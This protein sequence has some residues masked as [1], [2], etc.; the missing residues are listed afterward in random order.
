MR[1]L[2]FAGMLVASIL[3][4][5]NSLAVE[6]F[7]TEQDARKQCPSDTVVWLNT[8]S[9][10]VHYKGGRWY[11]HTKTGAYVCKQEIV[12]QAKHAESATKAVAWTPLGKINAFGGGATLYVDKSSVRTDAGNADMWVLVDFRN[13]QEVAGVRFLSSEFRKEYDCKNGQWR[14]LSSSM[15][16]KNMGAGQ[17]VQS[18][19]EPDEWKN[20]E[21]GSMAKTEWDVACQKSAHE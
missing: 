2:V 17:T 18:D 14:I 3:F 11:G 20:A 9:G 21:P 5:G 1:I 15:L 6:Q 13:A 4:Q 7:R 16:D 8:S 12:G 10:A 19:A